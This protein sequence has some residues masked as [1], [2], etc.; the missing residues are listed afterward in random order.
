MPSTFPPPIQPPAPLTPDDLSP[1]FLNAALRGDPAIAGRRVTRSTPTCLAES[2]ISRVYRLSLVWSDDSAPRTLIAKLPA[3]TAAGRAS[4]FAR[5]MTRREQRFYDVLAPRTPLHVPAAHALLGDDDGRAL[6]LE[7]LAPTGF[8]PVPAPRGLSLDEAAALLEAI[9]G[10]HA[11]WWQ[12]PR[13]DTLAQADWLYDYP[14]RGLDIDDSSEL[15][16]HW[17]AMLAAGHVPEGARDRGTELC[18]DIDALTARFLALPLTVIHGDLHL[19]NVCLHRPLDRPL[20]TGDTA[21]LDWQHTARG[22]A[23]YDLSKLLCTGLE[24]ADLASGLGD[25]LTRYHAALTR[26]GVDYPLPDLAADLI[27]AQRIVVATDI[28][29]GHAATSETPSPWTRRL[30]ASLAL[31]AFDLA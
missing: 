26:G 2:A 22:P 17:A 10:L 3:A 20:D 11:R 7:D 12:G 31:P 21:F 1:A 19:E 4:P 6:L 27:L 13:L 5:R 8:E 28:G 15:P 23:V 16:A 25:L 30:L 14:T 29:D 24:P 18:A 9:A